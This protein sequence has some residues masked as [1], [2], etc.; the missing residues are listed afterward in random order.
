VPRTLPTLLAALSLTLSACG[1]GTQYCATPSRANPETCIE[2]NIV[3]ALGPA[4]LAGGLY[5]SALCE[6]IG[7]DASPGTCPEEGR[8]GGCREESDGDVDIKAINWTYEGTLDELEC[9]ADD[10]KLDAAGNPVQGD[11]GDGPVDEPS[12]CSEAGGGLAAVHTTFANQTGAQGTL[13]WVDPGCVETQYAVVDAGGTHTQ[14]SFAGHVWVLRAGNGHPDGDIL[15]EG[16]LE[17]AD[18]GTT[19]TMD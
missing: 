4:G 8:V 17:A 15:W 3:G 13:Y 11:G 18:D 10:V 7:A 16:T 9:D 2:F 5:I 12:A 1:G 6:V 14:D 19:L